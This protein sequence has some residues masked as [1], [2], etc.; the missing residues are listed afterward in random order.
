MDS[1]RWFPYSEKALSLLASN[2]DHVL[3][4]LKLSRRPEGWMVGI[5][6]VLGRQGML[7][8]L[9]EHGHHNLVLANERGETK[10]LCAST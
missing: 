10:P 8:W 9:E 1:E 3:A 2:W 7:D 6:T 4:V 5:H